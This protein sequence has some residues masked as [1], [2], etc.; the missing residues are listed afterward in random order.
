MKLCL[1]SNRPFISPFDLA[2]V[3]KKP[4]NLFPPIACSIGNID[5]AL[6]CDQ[7]SVRSRKA[8]FQQLVALKLLAKVLLGYEPSEIARACA[9]GEMIELADDDDNQDSASL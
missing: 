9:A 4:V 1:N 8:G 5:A 3:G 7:S 2:F 6:V